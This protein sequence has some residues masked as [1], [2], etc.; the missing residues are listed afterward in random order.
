LNCLG[1]SDLSS[2]KIPKETLLSSR[3]LDEELMKF[4]EKR[5]FD[6]TDELQLTLTSQSVSTE[7]DKRVF[8]SCDKRLFGKT[9]K[10]RS[11][12]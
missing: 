11:K 3:L 10:E 6:P 5:V 7:S 4:Q 2:L 8:D 9:Q 12:N 1:V